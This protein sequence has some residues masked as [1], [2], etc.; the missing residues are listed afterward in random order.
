MSDVNVIFLVQWM[1][2]VLSKCKES[3]LALNHLFSCPETTLRSLWNWILFGLVINILV[4]SAN[5]IGTALFSM[6]LVLVLVLVFIYI[7]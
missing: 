2:Y 6:V 7:P 5:L 3:K 4:S 1:K